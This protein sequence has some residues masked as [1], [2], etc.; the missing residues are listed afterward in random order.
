MPGRGAAVL[1]PGIEFVRE[2]R[3]S[4]VKRI[5][6]PEPHSGLRIQPT[7][8]AVG[9]GGKCRRS[10]AAKEVRVPAPQ[11]TGKPIEDKESALADDT[12]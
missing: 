11:R 2:C 6:L 1:K 8:Q 10:E 4:R 7:A 12:N 5:A 9:L 3:L